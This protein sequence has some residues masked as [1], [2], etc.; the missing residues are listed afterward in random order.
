MCPIALSRV[1]ALDTL[2]GGSE[3]TLRLTQNCT[4]CD[5][6]SRFQSHE[7]ALWLIQRQEASSLGFGSDG[8]TS[9]LSCAKEAGG[10]KLAC[11]TTVTTLSPSRA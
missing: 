7:G 11:V 9:V 6:T 4:F 2:G 8:V 3:E 10:L 5:L 1:S